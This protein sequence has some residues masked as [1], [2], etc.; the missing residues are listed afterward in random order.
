MLS[1]HS[2]N[3][4]GNASILKP[5]I[6]SQ[7]VFSGDKKLLKPYTE[8]G[9]SNKNDLFDNTVGIKRHDVDED[10]IIKDLLDADKDEN[11]LIEAKPRSGK[12]VLC[13]RLAKQLE[14]M[15]HTVYSI[16]NYM[17]F[18]KPCLTHERL[19]E[20]IKEV[21]LLKPT[22][23]VFIFMDE[24]HFIPIVDYRK[25]NMSVRKAKKAK[26]NKNYQSPVKEQ[27]ER[28][29]LYKLLQFSKENKNVKLV[30]ATL[31]NALY[32]V[33]KDASPAQ[34]NLLEEIFPKET[35][36][37]IPEIHS[38]PEQMVQMMNRVLERAG[39]TSVPDYIEERIVLINK[40]LNIRNLLKHVYEGLLHNNDRVDNVNIKEEIST[41][42]WQGLYTRYLS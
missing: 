33:Q 3:K 32:K 2:S 1:L 17:E 23:K 16:D 22:D 34:K 6:K 25:Q 41:D 30:G 24:V 38:S 42:I 31:T 12:S 8:F 39:F 28:S 21:S 13:G 35:V 19:D 9:F 14:S 40:K 4:Y 37:T 20:I 36:L 26:R 29:V 27:P 7:V 18:S 5:C 11:L 10:K 15:G